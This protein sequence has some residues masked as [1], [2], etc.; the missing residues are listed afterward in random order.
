MLAGFVGPGESL[1]E[2]V[3]REVEEES[4]MTVHDPRF[5]TSQPWPFPQQVM[6]GF[7]GRADGGTP[8]PQDGELEDVRWFTREEVG[9]GLAGR[10]ADLVLPPGIS[11]SD[12]LVERWF[13]REVRAYASQMT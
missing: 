3:I 6:L 10:S 5:V 7:E 8:T 1:E 4:G 9:A 2:A 11:I 13:R 12:F